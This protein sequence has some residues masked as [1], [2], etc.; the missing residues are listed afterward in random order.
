MQ[1]YHEQRVYPDSCRLM[2]SS[3]HGLDFLAHWH[4]EAEL[5]F[6]TA[7][8]QRIG[9]NNHL[10]TLTAGQIILI[11]PLDIH[12]YE[13][14]DGAEGYMLIFA[15]EFLGRQILGH[16]GRWRIDDPGLLASLSGLAQ[17]MVM[18]TTER[19]A[20]YELAASGLLRLFFAWLIRPNPAACRL[21]L[22]NPRLQRFQTMRNI[23]DYLE[24]HYQEALSR[25]EAACR[26]N[27][28]PAHLSRL[29]KASTGMRLKEYLTKLRLESASRDI[30]Q[31]DRS[32]L[33][34]AL[35]NGFDSIRTFNRVFR[36]A[37]RRSPTDMRSAA[38]HGSVSQE[39][40]H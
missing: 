3:T 40:A 30:V 12:Y 23:L 4:E 16:S 9:V 13:K 18:E 8:R 6:I 10:S 1:A 24:N 26:F 25:T 28:S 22:D 11:A 15:P 32:V 29:F 20:N 19:L 21:P 35:D 5:I 38:Q 39:P 36:K 27:L 2:A 31:T 7:G 17:Q 34:I 14:C 37:Y 33:A